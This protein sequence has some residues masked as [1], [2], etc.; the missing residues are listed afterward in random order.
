M[1]RKSKMD[2]IEDIKRRKAEALQQ[3]YIAAVQQKA[4]EQHQVLEQLNRLEEMVRPYLGKGA[5]E[6][7]CTLKTAHPEKAVQV[8]GMLA[9]GIESGQLA[10]VIEDAQLKELLRRMEP[11]KKGFQLR[12]V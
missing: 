12:R 8:L 2:D 3:K 10:Q 4:R 11:Q 9:S 1:K 7:Y 6:R 5:F